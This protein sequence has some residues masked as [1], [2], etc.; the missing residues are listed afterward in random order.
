MKKMAL[1]LVFLVIMTL[2]VFAGRIVYTVDP[3][4]AS[5][6]PA[7]VVAGGQGEVK[8]IFNASELESG[9]VF[10]FTLDLTAKGSNVTYPVAVGFKE[11]GNKKDLDIAFEPAELTLNDGTTPVS[12]VVTVT[13]PE[14]D[15][16]KVKKLKAKFKVDAPKGAHLGNSAGVKIIIV[17]A[18]TAQE[19]LEAVTEE[20]GD[21]IIED[22][23]ETK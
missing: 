10:T 21:L 9:M 17:K 22:Q 11:K 14:D 7:T 13:L 12:T 20:I 23:A 3:S 19:F 6:Q 15:Y 8:V 2:P 16:T 18:A 1:W 5:P 4:T